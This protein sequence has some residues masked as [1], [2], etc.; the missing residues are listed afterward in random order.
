MSKSHQKKRNTGLMYEF[1][2]HYVSKQ[3]AEQNTENYTKAVKILK[4]NFRKN[5]ELVKELKLIRALVNSTVK[6]HPAAFELISEAKS[7]ARSINLEK[8][9]REKSILIKDI[10]HN[11][12]ND[13]CFY[14]VQL[15]NY[16]LLATVQMLIKNWQS[17]SLDLSRQTQ[18]VDNL[19]EHLVSEKNVISEVKNENSVGTVRLLMKVMTQK[20][21]EKYNNSFSAEQKSLIKAYAFTNA[22][23]NKITIERKLHDIKQNVISNISSYIK[24][25]QNKLVVEKLTEAKNKLENE[26]INECND[27]MIARFM[28]YLKLNEELTSAE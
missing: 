15:E 22:L 12:N 14:D 25:T 27:Q 5:S 21:N 11:L 6:T 19:V 13:N 2:V 8:L 23:D 26:N 4:K 28:M 16:K 20:L 18:Y 10:N 3:L 24:S 9:D 17:N 7:V 1:L